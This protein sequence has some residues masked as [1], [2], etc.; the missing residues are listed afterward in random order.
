[1]DRRDLCL[2]HRTGDLGTLQCLPELA[3]GTTT[4]G[5]DP[6]DKH[7]DA[8]WVRDTDGVLTIRKKFC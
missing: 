4:N 1:M 8:R 6:A 3:L 7:S 2:D 5:T